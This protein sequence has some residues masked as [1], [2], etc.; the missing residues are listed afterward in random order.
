MIWA[1]P[2]AAQEEPEIV[3]EL[4]G[5]P[6][7]AQT[8]WTIW[9]KNS[10]Q[11]SKQLRG[12]TRTEVLNRVSEVSTKDYAL[13]AKDGTQ[14]ILVQYGDSTHYRQLLFRAQEPQTF[15][16]CA[17]NIQEVLHVNETYQVTLRLTQKEF[18]AAYPKARRVFAAANSVL[19]RLETNG[20]EPRFFLF[21]KNRLT[22]IFTEEEAQQFIQT[23]RPAP[24]PKTASATSRQPAVRKALVSGGTLQDQMYMPRLIRR[25]TTEKSDR[26]AG[27]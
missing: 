14:Y 15:V 13:R 12:K 16:A 2:V 25:Q 6:Q 8:D 17:A 4:T 19:F 24:A 1:G 22:Q 9:D 10:T 3:I 5:K 26:E 21:D 7:R 11:L 23:K 18:T 27:S 20:Q